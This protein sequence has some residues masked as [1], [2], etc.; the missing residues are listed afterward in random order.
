VWLEPEESQ[1]RLEAEDA[2]AREKVKDLPPDP[3]HPPF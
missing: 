3:D 2:I 1:R